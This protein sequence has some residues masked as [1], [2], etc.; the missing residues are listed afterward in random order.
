V[1]VRGKH[2]KP[3]GFLLK[4]LVSSCILMLLMSAS[5]SAQRGIPI[6][7]FNVN[8]QVMNSPGYVYS[9]RFV[10]D[11]DTSLYRFISGFNLEGSEPLGG[12]VGY[13]DGNAG[14]I[15]ARL[16]AVKPNGEPDMSQVLAQETVPAYQRYLDSKSTYGAPG[17]TQ[18]LYFNMGGVQLKGGQMYA[19]TY[20]NADSSPTSNWFSEN[21]PTVKESVA[22]PN[23]VNN[24]DPN[25]PGAI[26][27]LDPREAVAWS[28]NG[29]QSWVWGRRAGEGN[30]PGAYAG[31]TSTDDG[32]RLPWYGWQTSASATPQSNQP[33]YAYKES[34]SYTLKA[35]SVP[36]TV[37]IT[38]AG[39]YAPAG[40]SVGVVTVRNA[41]TG[42][43]GHTSSLGG[44]LARGPLDKPVTVEAGQ[45]YE[46]A[47]SGTVL[48]EEGDSFIQTTFKI[49]TGSWPFTTVGQ[50]N[51]MAELYVLPNPWSAAPTSPEP[52][53]EPTPTPEPTPEPEPEPAPEPTPTPEPTPEPAPETE[54]E[55]A[56]GISPYS[57]KARFQPAI[58][59]SSEKSSLGPKYAVDGSSS[60]RWS[61]AF[62]DNQWWRVDLG[63]VRQVSK[64]SINWE[65][66]YASRYRIETSTNGTSY[67]VAATVSI[68]KKGRA[69][70][71]FSARGARYVRIWGVRRAT[72]WGFSFYDCEVFG[73]ADS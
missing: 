42:A 37:T 61:S 4:A 72:E 1:N 6:G 10:L 29:G 64:V 71:K 56:P 55:P 58:A 67:S 25:A 57:D 62:A 9:I 63:A 18:L 66:G 22:G 23:G 28:Q 35:S 3:F 70:T 68:S 19:M 33:Y 50:G 21:S 24:T 65:A 51:D 12:R 41:S 16:V 17:L 53:P 5:A 27:G 47:N 31:S 46:V 49:G 38:E 44:G 20:Q 45:S 39:G 15:R 26:A 11:K 69:T 30:T 52:A 13:A 48:K 59:S 54:P 2:H 34:G 60:T 43:S 32:T 8:N 36:R 40:A 14:T 7:M 73:P